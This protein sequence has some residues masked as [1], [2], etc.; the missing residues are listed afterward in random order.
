MKPAVA[1]KLKA[2]AVTIHRT[3]ST[4]NSDKSAFVATESCVLAAI[5]DASV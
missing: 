5:A 2:M 3:R 1:K 4:F